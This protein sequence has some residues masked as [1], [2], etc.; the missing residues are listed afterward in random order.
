MATNNYYQIYTEQV[1]QLAQTIVVKTDACAQAQNGYLEALASQGLAIVPD[2]DQPKTWRYYLNLAGQYHYTDQ[3]MYV[4][5]MD[6][7]ETILFDVENLKLHRATARAYAFGER[8]YQELVRKYPEQLGLINGILNPVDLDQAVAA[9]DGAILAWDVKLV[10][11]NEYSLIT[12]LQRHIDAFRLRWT[13]EQYALTNNLYVTGWLAVLH[14]MLV[15]TIM[16]LRNEAC[17]TNEAHSY[18]V[19][20]YLAS[21][22]IDN[23]AIDQLT[24]KQSLWLY[25][26]INYI[27][28]H[29]GW[30]DTLDWLIEHIMTERQIPIAEYTMRH[31]VSEMPDVIDPQLVFRRRDLNQW[32][33]SKATDLVSLDD[34]LDLEEPLAPDNH[35][36]R[37]ETQDTIR[38]LM[39]N[40]TTNVLMT[41]LLESAMIDYTDSTPYTMEDILANLWLELAATGMYRTVI[42][43]AHPKTGERIPLTAGE[44]YV[45]AMYA[46][47]KSHEVELVTVPS[48]YAERVPIYP[49]P[50]VNTLMKMVDASLVSREFAQQMRQLMPTLVQPIISTEAFYDFAHEQWL[51]ANR[52]R[53]WIATFEHRDGRGFAKGLVGRLYSDNMRRLQPEGKLYADFLAEHNIVTTG[54]SR[55]QWSAVF[56][57]I[58]RETTGLALNTKKSIADLQAAMVRLLLKLS[59]YSIQIARSINNSRIRMLDWP[60]WRVADWS[61]ASSDLILHPDLNVRFQSATG[62]FGHQVEYDVMA[63]QR[64]LTAEGMFW[65][66]EHYE[67]GHFGSL[68]DHSTKFHIQLDDG[69]CSIRHPVPY[70]ENS[71][72]V[73]PGP[74][75]EDWL[76]L[77]PIQQANFDDDYGNGRFTE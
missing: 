24:T 50:S 76:Q 58:S 67:L 42:S 8:G 69:I 71:R 70:P 49:V 25:R 34:V 40:S 3:A 63:F 37:V 29:P 77:T 48:F 7:L 10:E 52:Q 62:H 64:T 12:K 36:F 72:N 4:V 30:T 11:A 35:D 47:A 32:V 53:D 75:I 28:R 20:Q 38:H 46:L 44:A 26:N 56:L 21:R 57:D 18:H 17:N 16:A 54:I 55:E 27:I 61:G 74:G 59:S 66:R 73:P 13:N 14:L 22:G 41:K 39:Q 33:S 43:F 45:F 68:T 15:P 31:D 60:A 2:P 5:S 6:T 1:I 19:R 9:P 51:A 23:G 65:H